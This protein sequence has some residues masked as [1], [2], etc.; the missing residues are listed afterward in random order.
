MFVFTALLIFDE[1]QTGM[2]RTGKLFAY[3]H[4]GITPDIM[5][6][7]KA[8][9]NGLPIGATLVKEDIAAA[10]GPGAHAST[11]G[12]TPIVTAA[13]LETLKIMIEENVPERAQEMGAY[14]KE[15]L[16]LLKERHDCIIDIRGMGLLIGMKLTCLGAPIVTACLNKGFVINCIQERVLRFVPPLKVERKMID[17]LVACL[18]TVLAEMK[19]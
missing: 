8:L 17:A 7:A 16:T 18:D 4:F 9:G 19:V 6:L 14:F 1:I 15:R 11:F 10:F 3:D 5:T 12:G 13:A 2:G